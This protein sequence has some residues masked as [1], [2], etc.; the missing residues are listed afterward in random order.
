MVPSFIR[1]SEERNRRRG[2]EKRRKQ[3]EKRICENERKEK[4]NAAQ[5]APTTTAVTHNAVHRQ[6]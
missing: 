5:T 1:W 3:A 6:Q 2:I 4:G